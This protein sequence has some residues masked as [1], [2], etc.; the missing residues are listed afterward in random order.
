MYFINL[1]Y[2]NYQINV[3]VNTG[4][5]RALSIK[6]DLCSLGLNAEH[7]QKYFVGICTDGQYIQGGIEKHLKDALGMPDC[8]S[9]KWDMDHEIELKHKRVVSKTQWVK[10]IY[11]FTKLVKNIFSTLCFLYLLCEQKYSNLKQYLYVWCVFAGKSSKK[12]QLLQ[13]QNLFN[14]ENDING[15]TLKSF[16]EV[17]NFQL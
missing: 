8:F 11:D 5:E 3:N 6:R 12:S 1:E 2:L 17:T 14:D 7:L 16:S 4:I 9:V 15:K 13:Q 10:T